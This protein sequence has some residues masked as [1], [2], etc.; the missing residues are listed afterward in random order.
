MNKIPMTA[1][2]LAGGKSSRM[3]QDKALL[4]WGESTILEALVQ[5]TR[6]VF[7]ETFVIVSKHKN[8]KHLNLDGAVLFTDFLD[9]SGP[10]AGIYTGL[11]NSPYP[12]ACVLTCDM[13]LVDHVLLRELIHFWDENKKS[14]DVVCLQDSEG[15][16]QPFPGIYHR[17]S[18]YLIHGLLD[19]GETA[20][21][22]L[23]ERSVVRSL[24][25]DKTR[26]K[27][28]ANINTPDDYYATLNKNHPSTGNEALGVVAS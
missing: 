15:R 21:H 19:R 11:S 8:Y 7:S 18:K 27:S 13:P 1:L 26:E 14:C 6:S 12:E 9:D 17:F 16:L 3:G 10:L 22:S 5:L 2:I 4:P 28:L 24:R 23:L 25:L 20:L